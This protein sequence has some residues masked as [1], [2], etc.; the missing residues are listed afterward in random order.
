MILM[1]NQLISLSLPK[2][3]ALP[4]LAKQLKQIDFPI[5]GYQS[6]NRTYRPEVENLPVRAKIMAEKDVALQVAAGNYDIGFCGQDWIYEHSVR[7]RGTHLQILY[8]LKHESESVF[9]CSGKDGNIHNIKDLQSM[10]DTIEI[11]S[12]YPNIAEHFAIKHQLKR[13]KI[14]P[15]WGSVEAYPPEHAHVVILKANNEQELSDK[16]LIMLSQLL[17]ADVCL[18]VNQN[19]YKEKDLRPVLRY[20]LKLEAN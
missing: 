10:D 2:G 9:V 13:F 6:D 18:V 20:L 7:F 8:P 5:K 17:N 14:F 11:V 1:N 4:F 3:D 12:E 15:A 16:G 19:A